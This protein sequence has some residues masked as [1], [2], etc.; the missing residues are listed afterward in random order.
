MDEK[1]I[2]AQLAEVEDA[3]KKNEVHVLPVDGAGNVVNGHEER[4]DCPA[5]QPV[6]RRDGPLDDPVV[7]HV[8]PNHPGADP[9]IGRLS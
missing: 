6:L 5:C 9:S 8:D 3:L 2:K 4:L 7:V 1:T